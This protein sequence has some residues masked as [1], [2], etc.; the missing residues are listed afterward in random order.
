MKNIHGE[1]VPMAYAL[2]VIVGRIVVALVIMLV[3]GTV[4]Y[5]IR[6]PRVTFWQAVS[7]WWVIVIAVV[8]VV[9]SVAGSAASGV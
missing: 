1:E 6:R 8:L 4:Y 7:R 2:G 9:M 3:I 5:L